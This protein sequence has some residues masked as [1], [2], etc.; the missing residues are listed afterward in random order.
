MD[1]QSL[2][3]TN[4]VVVRSGDTLRQLVEEVK[5]SRRNLFPVLSDD[6]KFLGVIVFD[7]VRKI[8]F[9]TELYDTVRVDDIM[10][11][12]SE[13]DVVRSTDTLTDVVEKFRI[14]DP[15]DL[16]ARIDKQHGTH[17]IEHAEKIGL[18]SRKYHIVS[19]D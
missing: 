11:P 17:T 9:Q 5:N 6:D 19:I 1:M 18:G 7:D 12:L 13:G 8:I 15:T 10:H 3:E 14:N 4:F 16:L 2:I